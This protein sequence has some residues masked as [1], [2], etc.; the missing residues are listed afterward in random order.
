MLAQY[1]AL[2]FLN[3]WYSI[4]TK[5]GVSPEVNSK[6]LDII[7]LTVLIRFQMAKGYA[8]K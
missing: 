4:V 3:S 5:C 6:R 8:V 7:V 1:V 2:W